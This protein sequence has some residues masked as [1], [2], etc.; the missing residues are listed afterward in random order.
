MK[1]NDN[2]TEIL[3]GAR[4][5][6]SNSFKTSL[7]NC[8]FLFFFFLKY[9]CLLIYADNKTQSFQKISHCRPSIGAATAIQSLCLFPSKSSFF[10]FSSSSSPWDALPSV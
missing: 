6:D 4:D 8:L 10:W 9:I 7:A 2:Q 5:S 1:L 3:Y